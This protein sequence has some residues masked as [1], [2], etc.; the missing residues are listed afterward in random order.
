M[1]KKR[2]IIFGNIR[3][4][5]IAYK[6]INGDNFCMVGGVIDT[7]VESDFQEIQRKFLYDNNLPELT[8]DSMLSVKPDL[9][10]I[11]N[12]TKIIPSRYLFNFPIL[13][14][15]GGL[16]PKWRGLNANC[17]AI[18]NGEK[19][20]GYTLQKIDSG[21]DTGPMY[22]KFVVNIDDDEHF[23]EAKIRI[24]K[25]VNENI[26][27]II[28]KIVAGELD[29]IPQDDMLHTYTTKLR[30]EL[31]TIKDW[32]IKTDYLYNLYR[33]LGYPYGTGIYFSYKQ[34]KYEM[35]KMSKRKNIVNYIGT[36][37]V[38]VLT[39]GDS[40]LVKTAD[41]VISIDE[42][43]YDGCFIVPSALFKIGRNIY[44]IAGG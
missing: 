19:E 44:I 26:N 12:Y 42:L 10:I 22:H 7:V 25:I 37:G 3:N 40:I 24:Q 23:E 17:W 20:V 27:N 8:L 15:H 31:G 4:Y 9:G 2:L 13:N 41:N 11:I 28:T 35:T 6:L 32:N 36:P 5:D 14:I 1:Y 38:V 18:I 16:L 29:P 34:K 30:S 21:L 33:V 43:R 39:D